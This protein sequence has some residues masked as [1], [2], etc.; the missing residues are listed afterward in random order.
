M[1]KCLNV[2]THCERGIRRQAR[3]CCSAVYLRFSWHEMRWFRRVRGPNP[4]VVCGSTA[5]FVQSGP[6]ASRWTFVLGLLMAACCATAAASDSEDNAYSF[7]IPPQPPMV[8]NTVSDVSSSAET[9]QQEN[10]VVT[11][12]SEAGADVVD[13]MLVVETTEESTDKSADVGTTGLEQ[14]D[15]HKGRWQIVFNNTAAGLEY[16]H[17]H[18]VL[19]ASMLVEDKNMCKCENAVPE[20]DCVAYKFFLRVEEFCNA[21]DL[22]PK[23]DITVTTGTG[24]SLRTVFTMLV[25]PWDHEDDG[26]AGALPRLYKNDSAFPDKLSWYS[27]CNT[28]IGPFYVHTN[29]PFVFDVSGTSLS[30][31]KDCVHDARNA[32]DA[33]DHSDDG[34]DEESDGGNVLAPDE[35]FFDDVKETLA[36]LISSDDSDDSD[37]EES[38]GHNGGG[39]VLVADEK[40]DS[41]DVLPADDPSTDEIEEEPDVFEDQLHTDAYNYLLFGITPRQLRGRAKYAKRKAFNQNTRRRYKLRTS[42][43]TGEEQLYHVRGDDMCKARQE[44]LNI[45]SI[46]RNKF[47]KF[48]RVPRQRE[49]LEIVRRDHEEHHDGHN[50]AEPRIG[51]DYLITDLRK[52]YQAISG[53]NCA[54]CAAHEPIKKKPVEPILTTRRGE[55]VMFDL[56][57]YY[58]PDS[59][60][61]VWILTVVDHFTKYLWAHAFKSK[62]AKPIA[63]Y[64]YGIFTSNITMPERWHADNGGEFKNYHMEA[65]REMLSMNTN[66]KR[67]LLEYSHSMPRNPKC[68]GLVERANKTIKHSLHKIMIRDGWSPSEDMVWD[69]RPYLVKFTFNWNRKTIKLYGGCYNPCILM[70][71]QPP[72]AP[73]HDRIEP[74]ELLLVHEHC[75]AQMVRQAKKMETKVPTVTFKKGD[76][77]LVYKISQ[78]SHLDKKGKGGMSFPARAV[79]V[80]PSKTNPSSHY[81]IRWLSEGLYA[82]EKYGDVSKKM[83]GAWRLKLEQTKLTDG[84]TPE[85]DQAIIDEVLAEVADVLEEDSDDFWTGAAS[86]EDLKLDAG[87]EIAQRADRYVYAQLL[88]LYIRTFLRV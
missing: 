61:Y 1:V 3:M 83:W 11:T 24:P 2:F 63:Q 41:D 42:E 12:N 37:D 5:L 69:W 88:T 7:G 8:W 36:D 86:D 6:A 70:T 30:S 74:H 22:D 13:A 81:K 55:L 80:Q 49:G 64:L 35:M 60:G 78:R 82:H 39:N 47:Y 17:K 28:L 56:T 43:D 57:E 10:E 71:G 68:Q 75:A 79:V 31:T 85:E 76:V 44:S 65:V 26:G 77:V 62:E 59:E 21:L 33:S 29:G 50:V 27:H 4:S 14:D 40:S 23:H 20:E 38:E 32:G 87:E 48:R 52:K 67:M 73:D 54:V 58:V 9:V 25:Q 45:T 15:V 16:K 84:D 46:V 34:D 72:E 18:P 19:F 51:H 53:N 66:D